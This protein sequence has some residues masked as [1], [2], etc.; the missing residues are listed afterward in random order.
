MIKDNNNGINIVY[1]DLN[2]FGRGIV[3]NRSKQKQKKRN[4]MVEGVKTHII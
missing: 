3:R 4:F 1:D 2:K